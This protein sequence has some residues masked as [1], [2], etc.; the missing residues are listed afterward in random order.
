[1][2]GSLGTR[3]IIPIAQP[4][5]SSATAAAMP[6]MPTASLVRAAAVPTFAVTKLTKA[7][8]GT[9]LVIKGTFDP[10]LITTVRFVTTEKTARTAPVVPLKVA[11]TYLQVVVPPLLDPAAPRTILAN[12]QVFVDQQAAAGAKPKVTNAYKQLQVAPLPA[13]PKGFSTGKLTLIYLYKMQQIAEAGARELDDLTSEAQAQGSALDGSR[14]S[15]ALQDVA[16]E[17]AAAVSLVKSLTRGTTKSVGLGT[18]NGKPAIVDLKSLAL[19]DQLI[20]MQLKLAGTLSAPT[21]AAARS[22]HTAAAETYDSVTALL[23]Y[24]IS[25]SSAD[26]LQKIA[27]KLQESAWVNFGVGATVGVMSPNAPPLP[28]SASMA[29]AA[30]L[31][32]AGLGPAGWVVSARSAAPIVALDPNDPGALDRIGGLLRNER[33]LRQIDLFDRAMENVKGLLE[34]SPELVA[35]AVSAIA[36]LQ[37]SMEPP[38]DGPDPSEIEPEENV[39][40]VD[41]NGDPAGIF[42]T[43]DDDQTDDGWDESEIWGED[44]EDSEIP[45]YDEDGNEAGTI[46]MDWSDPDAEDPGLEVAFHDPSDAI[47]N[48]IYYLYQYGQQPRQG[49]NVHQSGPTPSASFQITNPSVLNSSNGYTFSTSP[50]NSNSNQG[51][52]SQTSSIRYRV[53]ADEYSL[54][55][56]GTKVEQIKRNYVNMGGFRSVAEAQAWI[57]NDKLH[58]YRTRYNAN[59]RIES[60]QDPYA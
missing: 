36:D 7:Q 57:R 48:L 54:N 13:L 9:V 60:Y 39:D 26:Q 25:S 28:V 5:L 12:Y 52:Q 34:D 4:W 40:L 38:P 56:A 19:L 55:I 3:A 49:Q 30:L 11:R 47:L 58:N 6:M 43:I 14:M 15:Q 31:S 59:Y 45:F 22:V 33:T 24:A 37:R 23:S 46:A 41:E 51:G 17:Y 8:A 18:L 44:P 10:S 32:V 50:G 35:L 29:G 27:G 42:E 1:M 53:L 20:Y 16:D 21:V 2:A